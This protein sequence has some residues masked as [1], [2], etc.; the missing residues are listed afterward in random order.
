[1][2]D[3]R[4]RYGSTYK[5]KIY[6]L[7]NGIPS[8]SPM[9]IRS[10]VVDSR[11]EAKSLLETLSDPPR[12]GIPTTFPTPPTGPTVT[13]ATG[14]SCGSTIVAP[15]CTCVA[16]H[17]TCASM[18]TR[19]IPCFKN[20]VPNTSAVERTSTT[21]HQT[22]SSNNKTRLKG[23]IDFFPMHRN[24]TK[25]LLAIHRDARFEASISACGRRLL[26]L[27]EGMFGKIYR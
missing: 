16:I 26:F 22:Q 18:P 7:P 5:R 11:W 19:W 24:H 27:W 9:S 14:M 20:T 25:R 3:M 8:F 6:L 21:P 1:M 10:Y 23:R 17:P 2:P 12:V 15:R 4:S 13:W